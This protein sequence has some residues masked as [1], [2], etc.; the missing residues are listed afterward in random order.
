MRAHQ[1]APRACLT[2]LQAAT[3]FSAAICLCFAPIRGATAAEPDPELRARQLVTTVCANCHGADGNS[4]QPSYPKLAG[5][6]AAYIKK[7]IREFV[8]GTRKHEAMSPVALRL[9]E[10]EVQALADFFS[11]K[12]PSP[13]Q[14]GDPRL[15]ARGRAIYFE[16]NVAA[17]LPSCDGCHAADGT[18]SPRFPRLAGQHADYLFKQLDDIKHGRRNTS[19]L[20]RAVSERLSADEMRALAVYL[21]GL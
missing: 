18:G 14:D 3:L 5:L 7:Q 15:A 16:G 11:S 4:T 2:R 8:S 13:G 1:D 12:A 21:G 17:G 10:D 19:P 20:M 6:Q 9:T